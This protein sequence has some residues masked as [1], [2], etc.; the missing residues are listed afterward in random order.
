MNKTMLIAVCLLATV[1]LTAQ[2]PTKPTTLYQGQT[3]TIGEVTLLLEADDLVVNNTSDS[4]RFYVNFNYE[5][6]YAINPAMAVH[7]CEYGPIFFKDTTSKRIV[8]RLELPNGDIE[9]IILFPKTLP[10]Q[11]MLDGGQLRG[12]HPASFFLYCFCHALAYIR[13]QTKKP[14]NHSHAFHKHNRSLSTS[15]K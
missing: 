11:V 8:L 9:K 4:S 10:P 15:R 5:K 14:T 13:S 7:V 1:A 6:C 2:K 12:Y 3:L